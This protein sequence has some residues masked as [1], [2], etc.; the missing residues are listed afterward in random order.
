MFLLWAPRDSDKSSTAFRVIYYLYCV[1]SALQLV[2]SLDFSAVAGKHIRNAQI[3]S[4]LFKAKGTEVKVVEWKIELKLFSWSYLCIL[5][6]SSLTAISWERPSGGIWIHWKQLVWMMITFPPLTPLLHALWS[7]ICA[8]T[9][10]D[11]RAHTAR[12]QRVLSL[13]LR[14]CLRDNFYR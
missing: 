4:R 3:L 7:L 11:W 6:W 1:C 12:K 8:T 13:L 10:T 2:P 14:L 9:Q 5:A